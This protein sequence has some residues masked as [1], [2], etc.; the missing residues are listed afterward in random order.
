MSID[1]RTQTISRVLRPYTL[2]PESSLLRDLWR[3]SYGHSNYTT[4]AGAAPRP[5]SAGLQTARYSASAIRPLP[6]ANLRRYLASVQFNHQIHHRPSIPVR[7]YDYCSA[8]ADFLT[9]CTPP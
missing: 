6:P 3:Q 9:V 2:V 5:A 7:G 4:Q 8:G 1:S